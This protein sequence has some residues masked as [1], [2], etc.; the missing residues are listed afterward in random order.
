MQATCL[1]ICTETEIEKFE[2]LNKQLQNDVRKSKSVNK[3]LVQQS[4][5]LRKAQEQL[6]FEVG[7]R[8]EILE[9]QEKAIQ[10][11]IHINTVVIHEPIRE[12]HQKIEGLPDNEMLTIMLKASA[13]ELSQVLESIKSTVESQQQINRNKIRYE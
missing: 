13:N 3:S 7:K 4:R 12:L 2:K 10:E 9:Q 8:T 6:E 11:Y 5:Q 1:W